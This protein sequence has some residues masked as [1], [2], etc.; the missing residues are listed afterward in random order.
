MKRKVLNFGLLSFGC[1]LPLSV[2]LTSCSYNNEIIIANFES[3]MDTDLMSTLS[4]KYRASFLYYGTNEDI[5]SKFEKNYDVAIPTTYE[6][7]TLMKKGWISKI[8]WS[9]FN[10]TDSDGNL[11][12]DGADALCLF[13]PTVQA[14]IEAV[15]NA[16]PELFDSGENLLDYAIP[17]FLQS[18]I[19]AY[20]GTEINEFNNISK[21][22]ELINLISPDNVNIDS[23][24]KPTSRSK[25]GCIDD[26]RTFF[27][28]CKLIQDQNEGLSEDEWDINPESEDYTSISDFT[29]TF[30]N[31]TNKFEKNWFYFNT[32]S[33]Q[34]LQSFSDPN[35][36]N[37]TFAYNGDIL[38]AATGA[39]LYDEY[40]SDTM[41]IFNPTY[42]PL[43]LDMIVFN[44]KNDGNEEK[45]DTI[46][47][48]V[49]DFA[50]DGADTS[51]TEISKTDEDGNFIY[52]PMQN[53][54][55]IQYTDPLNVINDYV[56]N[57]ENNYFSDLGY[58]ESQI[59]LYQ[60][61]YNI[62]ITEQSVSNIM[63][64]IE[65]PITDLEKSNMHWAYEPAKEKIG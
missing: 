23:R 20:K 59:A 11:I 22:N 34:I 27:D 8:D 49:K 29:N 3:Y 33:N 44:N 53:F 13:T 18:F 37:S 9:K 42:S 64:L 39:G 15:T 48:I 47:Q 43:A 16:Y 25:I 21:W 57:D 60:K 6:V 63:H 5:E 4:K 28:L 19:F 46:Y 10:L 35:G 26:T 54:D 56:M 30:N 38:Y 50:L 12:T 17:Y 40:N 14:I 2:L 31:L 65:K 55:F 58:D 41:H 32:D 62:D 7:L 1:F 36:N 45:I 52:G 24:F 61:I 51:V